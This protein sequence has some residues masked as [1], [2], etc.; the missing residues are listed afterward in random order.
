MDK[1]IGDSVILT[2]QADLKTSFSF[3]SAHKNLIS[4]SEYSHYLIRAGGFLGH[5]HF[6]KDTTK[7][8]VGLHKKSEPSVLCML[9]S[10]C[11]EHTG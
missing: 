7:D 2:R 10:A 3:D 11:G 9:T 8:G 6:L 4:R 5:N 1:Q